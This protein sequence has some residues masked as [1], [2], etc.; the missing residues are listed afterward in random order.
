[1]D[2]S[3]SKVREVNN[4]EGH[5]ILAAVRKVIQWWWSTAV[6]VVPKLFVWNFKWCCLHYESFICK[7]VPT[8]SLEPLNRLAITHSILQCLWLEPF[9]FILHILD[10]M[11]LSII[12]LLSK[13]ADDTTLLSR[14]EPVK[15]RLCQTAK[16]KEKVSDQ[17][18]GII[19]SPAYYAGRANATG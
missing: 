16:T 4:S 19:Y 11:P 2:L 6:L 15:T 13:Y 18:L 1:M 10:L 17:I 8:Q 14:V 5:K 9:L 3:E 7:Q 12:N